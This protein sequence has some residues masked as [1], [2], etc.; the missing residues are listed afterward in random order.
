MFV[1]ASC[2]KR[3]YVGIKNVALVPREER[4][5]TGQQQTTFGLSSSKII[6]LNQYSNNIGDGD[7]MVI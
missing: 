3:R 1:V 6:V 5:S 2:K 4:C 7:A